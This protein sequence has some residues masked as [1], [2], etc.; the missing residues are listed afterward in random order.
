ME[1]YRIDMKVRNNLILTKIEEQGYSSPHIFC[2]ATGISY[3]RLCKFLNM[4]ESI[5]DDRGR[6]KKSIVKLC[7]E[8]NCIPE[9]IF[10]ASQMEANLKTNK[11]TL[12][13]KEAE[14]I[15]I[16]NQSD[17]QKLL[18]EYYSIDQ[19]Q[20]SIETVLESLT[21]LEKKIIQMR[22]GLGEYDKE[23]TLEEIGERLELDGYK[24][25]ISRERVRQIEA[26]ALRKMRHPDKANKLMEYVREYEE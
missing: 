11:K 4:K 19:M 21:N 3:G 9:E 22:M 7:D 8:L 5:F 20:N 24:G 26:R 25:G 23:Y 17:N 2:K 16:M 14:A 18:E 6:I 15:F 1:E 12:K 10:S 13:V